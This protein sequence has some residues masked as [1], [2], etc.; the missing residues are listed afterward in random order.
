MK[1]SGIVTMN[2]TKFEVDYHRGKGFVKLEERVAELLPERTCYIRSIEDPAGNMHQI[3]TTFYIDLDRLCITDGLDNL[4][5]YYKLDY[6][7]RII[8]E[9]AS[10][11]KL[12]FEIMRYDNGVVNYPC[13][14]NIQLFPFVDAIAADMVNDED[15]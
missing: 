13:K 10:V 11:D 14:T 9:V 2:Q 3:R 8:F 1:R 6:E 5:E 7:V 12:L 4:M 15:Y